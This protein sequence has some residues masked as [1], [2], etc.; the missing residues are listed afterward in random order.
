MKIRK[1]VAALAVGAILCAGAAK[2]Q[3]KPA[4][5]AKVFKKPTIKAKPKPAP[6]PTAILA[7][8]LHLNSIPSDDVNLYTACAYANFKQLALAL[9]GVPGLD[10]T[11]GEFETEEE[12]SARVTKLSETINADRETIVCQSLAN[13][14]DAP[15]QYDADAETFSGSFNQNLRAEL[16]YKDLGSYVGKTRMGISFRIKRSLEID[17]NADLSLIS[18]NETPCRKI[19]YLD[20][21]YSLTVPRAEAIG[22]KRDAY[23]VIIGTLRSPYVTQEDSNPTPSLDEPY[24]DFTRTITV[25]FEPTRFVIVMPGGKRLLECSF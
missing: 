9:N 25:K 11:K 14:R 8:A 16:D 7:G 4:S 24:D 10:Q 5:P 20:V 1:S 12:F 15:F 22:V 19:S 17:Y 18:R 3:A 2:P 13:N 21:T 23:L 6:S